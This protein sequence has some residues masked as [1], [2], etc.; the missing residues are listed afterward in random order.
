MT[1]NE[2]QILSSRTLPQEPGF[3][4]NDGDAMLTWNALGLAG[5]SGEVVDLVKKGIFHKQG[6]DLIKIK[7][8]LG[9]TLWYIAAIATE[10]NMTLE[11]IMIENINKLR[12]RYPQ[13]FTIEDAILRR[14]EHLQINDSLDL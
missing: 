8:E 6:I 9:D 10:L 1:P 11:E 5:E 2:Y 4:V 7:K 13:G 14:D 3:D 12:A